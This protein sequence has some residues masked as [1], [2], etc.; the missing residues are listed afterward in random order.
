MGGDVAGGGHVQPGYSCV[1]QQSADSQTTQSAAAAASQNTA[2]E[3]NGVT[4]D[5]MSCNC[6][7][8]LSSLTFVN[9]AF[10]HI[11]THT[12][13]HVSKRSQFSREP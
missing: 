13:V 3:L 11:N 6:C 1:E 2:A 7:F 10:D 12:H 5:G 8:I 9:A 4:G